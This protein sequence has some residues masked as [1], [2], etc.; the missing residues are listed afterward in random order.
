MNPPGEHSLIQP[1][2]GL[3]NH[4]L[5]FDFQEV[6]YKD[7]APNFIISGVIVCLFNAYLGYAYWDKYKA[8]FKR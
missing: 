6:V 3:I 1:L 8:L 5:L 2:T 7:I 4:R